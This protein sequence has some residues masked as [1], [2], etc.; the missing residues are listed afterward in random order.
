MFSSS[1][2]HAISPTRVPWNRSR[3]IIDKSHSMKTTTNKGGKF[4]RFNNN[5]KLLN[6]FITN[7]N[8][9]SGSPIPPKYPARKKR[10]FIPTRIDTQYENLR[11]KCNVKMV[12]SLV[13]HLGQMSDCTRFRRRS[14]ERVGIAWWQT[15]QMKNLIFSG[16]T[17]FQIQ[18][19]ELLLCTNIL[20][21]SNQL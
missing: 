19:Q 13:E 2:N 15:L 14:N 16:A 18:L 6:S 17:I 8:Q 11:C 1:E 20:C 4:M 7:S 21:C 10:S 5:S 9:I 3:G 12:S